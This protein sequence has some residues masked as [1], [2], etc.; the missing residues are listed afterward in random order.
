LPAGDFRRSAINKMTQYKWFKTSEQ[1]KSDY[2]DR[3][4]DRARVLHCTFYWYVKGEGVYKANLCKCCMSIVLLQSTLWNLVFGTWTVWGL[5]AG[6]I[7]III[8]TFKYIK[9]LFRF[10]RREMNDERLKA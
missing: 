9:Y 5:F 7:F 3:C 2:C 10:K 8:N 1:S 4:N 6:P